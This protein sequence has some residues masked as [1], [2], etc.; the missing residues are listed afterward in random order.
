MS[1]WGVYFPAPDLCVETLP[2]GFE[3]HHL[4]TR[5]QSPGEQMVFF[6]QIRLFSVPHPLKTTSFLQVTLAGNHHRASSPHGL[7][8]AEQT[9][10]TKQPNRTEPNRA[11]GVAPVGVSAPAPQA[12]WYPV[13]AWSLHHTPRPGWSWGGTVPTS[14]GLSARLTS[15][16]EAPGLGRPRGAGEEAG[17]SICPSQ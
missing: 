10:V 17:S 2:G 8:A 3:N 13:P 16:P 6:S 15:S 9:W 12:R 4:H 1:S 11:T 14:L 7:S 5:T